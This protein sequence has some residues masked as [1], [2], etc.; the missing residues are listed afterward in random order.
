M[1]RLVVSDENL[2]AF[3]VTPSVALNARIDFVILSALACLAD[4]RGRGDAGMKVV[5]LKAPSG[6]TGATAFPRPWFLAALQ[7]LPRLGRWLG[8]VLIVQRLAIRRAVS[9][10][11]AT[12]RASVAGC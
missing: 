7:A 9:I 3:V 10:L 5:S 8:P 4:S 11:R 12:V 2:A 1:G 6:V